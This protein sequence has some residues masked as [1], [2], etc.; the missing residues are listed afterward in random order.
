M[1][2]FLRPALGYPA[3][4][5]PAT[6][7]RPVDLPLH[8]RGAAIAPSSA[9]HLF[10][11]AADL[12][13]W[14]HEDIPLPSFEFT[15]TS[16]GPSEGQT[17]GRTPEGT[18]L[19]GLALLITK[20]NTSCCLRVYRGDHGSCRLEKNEKRGATKLQL[21][22]QGFGADCFPGVKYSAGVREGT[23]ERGHLG[24]LLCVFV[25]APAGNGISFMLKRTV[26]V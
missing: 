13:G 8:F 4:K 25:R 2:L 6:Q 23:G 10:Q 17:V 3:E 24:R 22:S 9:H 15:S 19:V 7:V 1:L 5:L 18:T 16:L 26:H 21:Q 14:G 12:P 11:G 20:T